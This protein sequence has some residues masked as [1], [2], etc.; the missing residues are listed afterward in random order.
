MCLSRIIESAVYLYL[1]RTSQHDS[2]L[3]EA[4]LEQAKELGVGHCVAL[5]DCISAMPARFSNGI[6]R[7]QRLEHR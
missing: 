3:S 2:N 7:G 4:I 6:L 5:W 1:Y